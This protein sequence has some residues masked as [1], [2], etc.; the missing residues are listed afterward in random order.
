MKTA[1]LGALRVSAIGL[2]LWQLGSPSW[3]TR[4][5]GSGVEVVGRAVEEGINLF[6]TAEIYGWGRSERLLG[7][8]LRELGVGDEVV[9]ATKVGGFRTIPYTIRKAAEGSRRRL[10]RTPD[11]VQYHWP[12]PIHTPLCTVMRGLERLVE[13]GLAHYIGLSNFNA[14]LLEKALQCLHRHEPISIQVQYS[15]AYR[16]PELRLLPLAGR[17]GLTPIA[18]S[19][20]A[21][22]SLAGATSPK[23]WA[24]RTD[25]VFKEASR[26]ARLQE[27]LR[28]IAGEHD[29]TMAQ[30]ALAW[31]IHQGALPI[32]GTRRLERVSEYA[33]SMKIRFSEDELRLLD[34]ASSRYRTRWGSCYSSLRWMR[35]VPSPIQYLSIRLM[36]GV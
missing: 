34:E 24:Q 25:P 22:G 28:R 5:I 1:R 32:P 27:A 16:T 31:L 29:A 19:P 33:G 6:D 35:L 17:R 10:G 8:A 20:L 9:V 7:E 2:G 23:A 11:L 4:G 30:V 26:D 13:E 15:L 36:G 14:V 18:W 3:G 21:K 12:P